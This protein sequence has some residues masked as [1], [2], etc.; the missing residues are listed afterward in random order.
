MSRSGRNRRFPLV[1]SCIWLGC[2]G[3]VERQ[4]DVQLVRSGDTTTFRLDGLEL[5]RGWRPDPRGTCLDQRLVDEL[6]LD[7]TAGAA[8]L[9]GPVVAVGNAR[10]HNIVLYSEDG[11]WRTIGRR[12]TGPGEFETITWVGRLT[13]DTGLA[14]DARFRR[15]SAFTWNDGVVWS[16]TIPVPPPEDGTTVAGVAGSVADGRIVVI[17][18]GAPVHDPGRH[19]VPLVV[20]LWDRSTA[21][22]ERWVT[23]AG[24]EVQL[25]DLDGPGVGL[26]TPL[27]QL[28]SLVRVAGDMVV[29]ADTDRLAV[30]MLISTKESVQLEIGVPPQPMRKSDLTRALNELDAD[31]RRVSPAVKEALAA[32]APSNLPLISDIHAASTERVIVRARVSD[33]RG[34][35]GHIW[36]VLSPQGEIIAQSPEP[37]GLDIVDIW[38]GRALSLSQTPW[39]VRVPCIHQI[40]GVD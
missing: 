1:M 6:A 21:S 7:A 14:Y 19:R 36:W 38:E 34:G 40:H 20:Y 25:I 27:F 13:A 37:H 12:G 23:S 18:Y 33:G 35:N 32:L 17:T 29:I 16:E 22:L 8:F 2:S 31:R 3:P 39:G 4:I 15:A 28:E 10:S 24:R 5:D 9:D 11:A 26:L 30:R